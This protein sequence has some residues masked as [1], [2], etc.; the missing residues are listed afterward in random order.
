MRRAHLLLVLAVC[1]AWGGNFLAAAQALSHFPAFLC[2]ALRLSI[3]LVCLAPLMKP[4]PRGQRPLIL[5]IAVLN[6]VLHFGLVFAALR[7]AGDI[8]SVAVAFQ[9]YIP[10]SAL[11]AVA[12][13]KEPLDARLGA[14]IAL[15]FIGVLVLRFDPLALDA[16]GALAL[17]TCSGIAL[18]LA[19]TLTR[20]VRGVTPLGLQAWSAA[21]AIPVLCAVSWVLE[22]DQLEVIATARWLDWAGIAYSAIAAS[23]FGHT[24]VFW[25]VQR[26]PVAQVT[27]Y[28]LLSPLISVTLGIVVWGDRPGVELALGGAMV[29]SGVLV[30]ALRGRVAPQQAPAVE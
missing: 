18:A 8:S 4:L 28:L 2:T 12:L 10:M 24:A 30:V 15:A 14:G 27:P 16:P 20:R 5:A 7:L 29:L 21:I 17:T 22:R 9:A 19:T 26:Y 13:L 23:V 3:V 25:L 6:G 11:L 1:V